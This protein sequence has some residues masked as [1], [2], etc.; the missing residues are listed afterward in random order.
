MEKAAAKRKMTQAEGNAKRSEQNK[1][2][3]GYA[4]KMNKG[5]YANCGASM[6]PAQKSTQMMK[7]GYARKK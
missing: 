5:G 3:G 7:G 2:K 4:K 1:A 6:K